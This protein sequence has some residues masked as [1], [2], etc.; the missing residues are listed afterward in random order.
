MTSRASTLSAIERYEWM[1][2]NQGF[3]IEDLFWDQNPAALCGVV[4]V[5]GKG[6]N[7]ADLLLAGQLEPPA[8]HVRR[9]VGVSRAPT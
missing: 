4:D 2:W 9:R 8:G 5:V 1:S 3:R 6:H 7:G